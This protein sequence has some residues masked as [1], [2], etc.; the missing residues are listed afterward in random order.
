VFGEEE[1]RGSL[2]AFGELPLQGIPGGQHH[3]VGADLA[4]TFGRSWVTLGLM[5]GLTPLFPET[6]QFMPRLIWAVAL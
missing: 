2:E 4:W 3:F 5:V 1:L 6:P